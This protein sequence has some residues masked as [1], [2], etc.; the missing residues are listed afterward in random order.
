MK[1]KFN[2]ILAFLGGVIIKSVK[3][4]PTIKGTVK[5]IDK[6]AIALEKTKS[7]IVNIKEKSENSYEDD[8]NINDYAIQNLEYSSNRI[9]NESVS[10][11]NILG[12]RAVIDTKQNLNHAKEKL[13]KISFKQTEKSKPVLKRGIK[14]SGRLLKH[15]KKI[16]VEN[17]KAT[18]R[19]KKFVQETTKKTIYGIKKATKVSI[20]SVKTIILGTKA[21]LS[22]LIAGGW[23][24]LTIIVIMSVIGLLFT[25]DF[26]I[27]LSSEGANENKPMD[28]VINEIDMELF[29]KI[30]TIKVNNL[31]DEYRINYNPSKWEEILAIYA[32]KVIDNEKLDVVT[33]DQKKIDLLKD[34]YWNMNTIDYQII[35]ENE[36]NILQ[37]DI[38]GKTL[39]NTMSIYD[40]NSKQKSRIE[41][42]LSEKHTDLWSTVILGIDKDIF[43][44]PVLSEFYITS[45][46]SSEHQAID[47]SS[48]HGDNIYSIYNGTVIIA[49]GGCIVGDLQC[50]NTAG[51]YVIIQ[52]NGIN[53]ISSYLHL[54]KINV[55][56]G[57]KVNKGDVI[58]TMGNT[59]NVIPIP[60]DINSKLG[61]HLHFVLYK[62]NNYSSA[63]VINPSQL[64][65]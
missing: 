10:G 11:S 46:Y 32:I 2:I 20:T 50:N 43:D 25:S 26:G 14:K 6:S 56:V 9:L 15:D 34:I 38:I 61:T 36:K 47:V 33:I 29:N 64:F 31:H 55:K 23:V 54:D 53:Y 27:F 51:N 8:S 58:G 65:H 16:I 28:E 4:K 60:T 35:K 41:T 39:E 19:A 3:T 52:H 1:N 42:L 12:K 7:S 57:D 22:A 30:E 21:L 37:I 24:S 63:K 49:S 5:S 45:L 59:G 40:F 18:E 17:I 48:F 62:G 13:R 44:C